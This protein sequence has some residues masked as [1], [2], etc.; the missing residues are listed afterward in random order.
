[1]NT[2]PAPEKPSFDRRTQEQRVRTRLVLRHLRQTRPGPGMQVIFFSFGLLALLGG[3]WVTQR[4]HWPLALA[5]LALL[6]VAVLGVA[7][8]LAWNRQ[9]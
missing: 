6:P 3:L 4:L 5:M 2:C 9:R 7:A 8:S 1:M